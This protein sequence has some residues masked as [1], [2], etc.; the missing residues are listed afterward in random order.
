MSTTSWH[1]ERELGADAMPV[2]AMF[3]LFVAALLYVGLIYYLDGRKAP[4]WMRVFLAVLRIAV[5]V[6]AFA[7]LLGPKLVMQQVKTEKSTVIVLVDQSLSMGH[8]DPLLD[9]SE[10]DDYRKVIDPKTLL[11]VKA[12]VPGAKDE[13]VMMKELTLAQLRR[14]PRIDLVNA[15][16]KS[17]TTGNN[18]LDDL[19]QHHQVLLYQFGDSAGPWTAHKPNEPAGTPA[20]SP[21]NAA[22]GGAP[23]E[24]KAPAYKPGQDF[25]FEAYAPSTR[26]AQALRVAR[27]ERNSYSLAGVVLI[28]DGQETESTE[29]VK[30]AAKDFDK[31][32]LPIPVDTVM[33]GSPKQP[34]DAAIIRVRG[35]TKLNEGDNM[36]VNF[37]VKQ[38]NLPSSKFAPEKPVLELVDEKGMVLDS[39]V[40]EG[41]DQSDTTPVKV[42]FVV[43]TPP[44][45]SPQGTDT[46]MWVGR[47][48]ND[49]R[50]WD[51]NLSNNQKDFFFTVSKR[52]L[53]VLYVEGQNAP[54]WEWHYLKNG[55]RRDKTVLFDTL[56]GVCSDS[57]NPDDRSWF[58]DGSTDK[59][60]PLTGFPHKYKNEKGIEV[61]PLD[62]YDVI[63]LGDVSPDMFSKGD[64]E[65]MVKFVTD[66]GGALVFLAGPYRMPYTWLNTP[67]ADLIP[68]VFKD[69]PDTGDEIWDQEWQLKPTEEG[70][71]EHWT[72]LD[73]NL[74]ES[75]QLYSE[76]PGLYWYCRAV[77][78]AKLLA[79]VIF[80]HPEVNGVD[81]NPLPI[82]ATMPVGHGNTMF[83]GTDELWRLRK[84][85]D[86]E[87]F[88]KLWFEGI[89]SLVATR[90]R[91]NLSAPK[92][93]GV[94]GES[95][96]IEGDI[97]K[98][99]VPTMAPNGTLSV[100]LS[101]ADPTFESRTIKLELE[102][103]TENKYRTT[104]I[105]PKEGR[106]TVKMNDE[107]GNP[108]ANLD[109]TIEN[110]SAETERFEANKQMLT[111]IAD[112]TQGSMVELPHIDDLADT[113]HLPVR[114]RTYTTPGQEDRNTIDW[115]LWAL[116]LVLIC[117][118][119]SLRKIY[120]MQ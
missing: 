30:L 10:L 70:M 33:V 6:V 84:R 66:H 85:Y 24:Q 34:S 51:N 21:A 20:S 109:I 96:A 71:L 27:N 106:Y 29:A 18:F 95:F 91:Y 42:T 115:W 77:Q 14:V 56:L 7:I 32:D 92:E 69:Q 40:I 12:A 48:K 53:K 117:L 4:T 73:E 113:K 5:L 94:V 38:T 60:E 64:P 67:L 15:V 120:R 16:L 31:G 22:T 49:L 65:A 114:D 23:E 79:K 13:Q 76:M 89:R 107:N 98:D 112:Y 101:S 104:Y 11:T 75:N 9:K 100:T 61:D 47:I 17:K 99:L 41:Y 39:K 57:T 44:V 8:G 81:N 93:T 43:P 63:I 3:F 50:Q 59:T 86:N 36:V 72:Q 2:W 19:S 111:T 62:D 118:E 45:E 35:A 54:R 78:K 37:Y 83:V 103:G 58:W 90:G 52:R 97:A 88:Y 68:V 55:L 80:A 105:F 25:T 26:I 1:L 108:A 116:F 46:H 110:P 119:W 87:Y 82:I 28:S 74:A 102:K